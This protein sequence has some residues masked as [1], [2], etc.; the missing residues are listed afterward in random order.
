MFQI[1]NRNI[2]SLFGNNYIKSCNLEIFSK[3]VI[4]F[5][6]EL[7]KGIFE[8]KNFKEYPD[9]ISYAFWIR[10]NN[11]ISLKKGYETSNKSYIGRGIA[12]HVVP[13][14][15]P[16]NFIY[17]LTYGLLSGNANLIKLPEKNFIQINLIVNLIKKILKK[18]NFKILNKTIMF[19]KYDKKNVNLTSLISLNSDVRVVWGGDKTVMELKNIPTK[20]NSIDINFPDK[21]SFCIIDTDNLKINFKKL[22]KNF[23]NDTYLYDQNACSSPHLVLWY[24]KQTKKF[25]NFFWNELSVLVKQKYDLPSIHLMEKLEKK[26]ID[27]SINLQNIKIYDVNKNIMIANFKNLIKNIDSYRGK[28]GYFYEHDIKNL[29]DIKKICN[30][31]FQTLTYFLNKNSILENFLKENNFVGVNRIVP[32]GKALEMSLNWDGNDLIRIMSKK[33]EKDLNVNIK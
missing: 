8:D 17:S 29:K 23:Y 28:W 1:K 2:K 33:I 13:S 22:V 30:S 7:S 21:Y 10:E 27:Q 16:T 9:I 32:I 15:V 6:S 19:I 26:M 14:N 18:K 31:K 24:G 20:P 4:K 3:I 25:K 11:L 5:L 12:F